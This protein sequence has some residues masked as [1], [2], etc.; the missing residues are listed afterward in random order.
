[1]ALSTLFEPLQA[2]PIGRLVAESTWMFPTLETVHVFALVVVAGSILVVDLR[3]LGV[4]S[5]NQ[6]VTTLSN[7]LLPWTWG[8]FVLAAISG[9]ML[10]F[11]RAADYVAVSY[12]IAKFVAMGLAALNMLVFHFL[13]YRGVAGW[14][15]GPTTGQAKL[16]GLLSIV[17]WAT[18]IVCARKVGFLI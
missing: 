6:R 2:S 16:A 4:A 10:F 18:V 11:A 13:T 17:L 9:A 1:M 14:D 3:L 8:A 5:T 15:L 12:F 7:E